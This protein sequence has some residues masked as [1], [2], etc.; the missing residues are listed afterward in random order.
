MSKYFILFLFFLTLV[1]AKM[2]SVDYRVEFGIIG[3]VAKVHTD[4]RNNGQTYMIDTHLSV[5][6]MLAK[7]VTDNLKERH[8]C[9]GTIDK[10][11][12]LIATSY[13]M[14]KSYGKYNSNTL[15]TVNHKN[16][17]IYK[18]FK[19]WKSKLGQTKGMVDTYSEKLNY[20]SKDDLITFFLNLNHYITNKKLSKN[21]IFKVVGADKKNGRVDIRIPARKE[22][23]EM[24]KLLNTAKKGEWIMNLVMHRQLYNSKKG[25]LMVHMGADGFIQKAVLKDLILLGDVRIIKE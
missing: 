14:Q 20:Y 18:T 6:G 24:M 23:K 4:Y 1:D 22:K 15:Y 10:N 13:E 7:K 3:Q 8:I 12:L 17:S 11:G 25:E 5:I 2:I 21:Y 16:K 9:K 19:K